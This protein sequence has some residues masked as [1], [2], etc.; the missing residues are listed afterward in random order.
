MPDVLTPSP[1][2][3]S[4]APAGDFRIE[5]EFLAERIVVVAPSSLTFGRSADLVID[6]NPFLHRVVGRFV[7]REGI[8]WLQNHCRRASLEV[9]DAAGTRGTI[10]PSGQFPLAP[11]EAAVRF[12]AG[13]TNYELVCRVEGRSEPHW[14][15]GASA[16]TATVDFGLVPLTENQHRLL[17]ALCAPRLTGREHIPPSHSAASSLGW[18]ITKFNRQLDHLCTKLRRAG[19][20]GLRGDPASRALDRRAALVEHALANGLVTEGD[21]GLVRPIDT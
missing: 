2:H 16:D 13:P 12:G 9:E 10:S 11:S 20:R 15:L 1:R 4:R 21:L 5:V 3:T 19:V 8:W 14:S 6:Q 18:T 17:V 7:H